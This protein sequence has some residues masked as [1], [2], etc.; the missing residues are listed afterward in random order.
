MPAYSLKL[1]LVVDVSGGDQGAV[2][3]QANPK[4]TA[5]LAR[6]CVAY[7]PSFDQTY[8]CSSVGPDASAAVIWEH[9]RQNGIKFGVY[10]YI[11]Q[12]QIDWQAQ[13][14]INYCKQAGFH[15][16]GHW[17]LD[18]PP[19]A[20][21]EV[22]IPS[23]PQNP[24]TGYVPP[25]MFE[26]W[27]AQVKQWLDVVE[28]ALGVKP[29][30]YTARPQWKWLLSDGGSGDAPSWTSQYKYWIKWYPY[31]DYVDANQSLPDSSLPAG[32]SQGLIVLWQYAEDGG[33]QGFQYEDL[34]V[35]INTGIQI[36]TSPTPTPCPDPNPTPAPTFD[37]THPDTTSTST[38]F[39]G[40]PI[41]I[42]D[43]KYN[44]PRQIVAHLIKIPLTMTGLKFMVMP[45]MNPGSVV[46]VNAMTVID[47]LKT[48]RTMKIAINGDQ[49]Q[50]M[51][52]AGQ[53]TCPFGR[54]A[55]QGD[56]YVKNNNE[57]TLYISANNS[58]SLAKPAA[59][60]NAISYNHTL[61][62][63]GYAVQGLDT[64][65]IAP[66]TGIGWTDALAYFVLVDGI[67]GQS[68]LT[69]M[70]FAELMSSLKVQFAINMDGGG[71]TSGAMHLSDGTLRLINT[72][73]DNNMPGTMR[74]LGSILGVTW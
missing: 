56:M 72:P 14:F 60:Y 59:V 73:S 42:E 35:P 48:Y 3:D 40:S 70:E 25:V 10:A 43:R 30:I 21:V 15:V 23:I 27:A 62:V 7:Y 2:L 4:P 55:S 57:D 12:G 1:P 26:A 19:I 5:V 64:G 24:P 65:Q 52:A 74:P 41:S 18:F 6:A 20:D 22:E 66:R 34:N 8:L 47:F 67:E 16:N 13:T 49:F 39:P 31:S 58:F 44:S 61:V 51:V 36:F 71:S 29:W 50:P 33:A 46:P 53:H 37:P 28:N 63:N 45:H 32:I 11:L 54:T 17:V 9:A 38:P 68:G 69:L